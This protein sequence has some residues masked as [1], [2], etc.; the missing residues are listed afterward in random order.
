MDVEQSGIAGHWV[1]TPRRF[2]DDRG[3]FLELFTQ[4]SL[5]EATGRDLHLAQ[6]NLSVSHRGVLRGV[7]YADVP[8]GQAKYVT[9]VAGAVLD[10]VVDLRVGSPTFGRHEAVLL[11]AVTQRA[12]FVA[13]GLGHAFLSLQDGSTVVYACSTG[14]SPGAE[15]GVH[16]LDADLAIDWPT[17]DEAGEPLRPLLS[18]KDEAAP[19]LSAAL[20]A[21]ALPVFAPDGA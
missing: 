20:A 19:S 16:P 18:P 4:T 21:G 9:C 11:D 15:H 8:P 3:H 6:T 5:Q 2:A 10:V 12:V 14:Y 7:H 17:T 1:F 13:E